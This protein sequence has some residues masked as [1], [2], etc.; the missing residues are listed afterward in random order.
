LKEYQKEKADGEAQ[1]EIGMEYFDREPSERS[2]DRGS[3][4]SKGS[5][6]VGGGGRASK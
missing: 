4:A 6:R 5:R 3:R 2:Y 1:T